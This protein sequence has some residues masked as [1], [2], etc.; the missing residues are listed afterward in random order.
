MDCGSTLV[1]L[2]GLF[3]AAWSLYLSY[4]S[5]ASAYRELLYRKQFDGY[6]ELVERLTSVYGAAAQF[7]ADHEWRLDDTTRPQFAA[8]IDPQVRALYLKAYGYAVFMPKRV[9]DEVFR[10]LNVLLALSASKEAAARYPKE[11]VY[12]DNHGDVLQQA[13]EKVI[14]AA[15]AGLGT[16]PLS[17]E[18]L[19]MIGG[20]PG[21][22]I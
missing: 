7:L 6:T 12:A 21:P 11:I 22:Q 4:K 8:Q 20:G 2:G 13:F 3:V 5:R 10:F 19:K 16:E 18:T 15:R 1:G 9:T 17:Q 14:E